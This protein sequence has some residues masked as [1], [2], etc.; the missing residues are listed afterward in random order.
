MLTDFER[1]SDHARNIGESV[2]EIIEKKIRFSE[3]ADKGLRVLENALSDITYVTIQAFINSD[4]E[5]ALLIDPLEEV[6]DDLCDELKADHTERIGRGEC[7]LENGF[8]YNDMLTDY[9]RIADHCANVAVDLLESEKE[10]FR[11]HEYHKSLKYRQ[12]EQ[13][14]S[15][16]N[17]YKGKYALENQQDA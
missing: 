6:I 16:F 13:Y 17:Y 3:A 5:K 2:N 12:N 1:M 10:E 8:V 11:S 9:E 15:Y 7:T 14:N 4:T